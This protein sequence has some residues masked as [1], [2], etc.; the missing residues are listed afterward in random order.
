MIKGGESRRGVALIVVLG[1]LSIMIVMAV[2]FITQARM[3]RLVS[4]S[5]LEGMR[6][7]QL[8]RTALHAAMN[9][10][11]VELSAAQLVM[12]PSNSAYD[13]FVSVPPNAMAGM[14]GR[15]IGEDGVNPM[16]GEVED[17]IPRKF[18]N[19][20]YSANTTVSNEAQWILVRENPASPQPSRILG[21][22]AYAI[23][24]MSGGIDAN[25]I[26]KDDSVGGGDARMPSNRIR[27]SSRQVP[28]GLLPETANASQFKSYRNGWKGFDSLYALIK[29]TDGYP[30]DG[31]AGS[32]S[33]WEPER[34]EGAAPAALH[35]NLVSDLVPF[36]LSAF[37]GGR[38]N[39]A[40]NTW[41][42]FVQCNDSTPWSTVL[43]PIAGQ[44]AAGWQGWIANALYDYTH[45]TKVPQGT[46]Y[47]SPKNVP[48]FNEIVATYSLDEQPSGT[49]STYR[50]LLN[51]EFEFWY[52]FPSETNK[53]TSVFRLAAP[54]VTG[55][56]AAT[57]AGQIHM[58]VMMTTPT[59][60][61]AVQFGSAAAVP[62][63]LTV[64]ANY[65]TNRPYTPTAPGTNFVYTIPI[66]SM[67]GD[68]LPSGGALVVRGVRIA[69]PIYLQL[70]SSPGG[71]ADMIPGEL[72]F[73]G[74]GTTLRDSGVGARTVAMAATDPRLNHLAGQWVAEVPS[75][76]RMNAWDAATRT[77][78]E[79]EGTNMFC[80]NGPMETPAELGL[81]SNGRLWETIDLC[82][83]DA[84]NVLANLVTDTNLYAKWAASSAVAAQRVF[85]TN[86]TINP[87]T[88][89]SNV[90]ATAFFDLA[91]HEVPNT[92][93][94]FAATAAID[95]LTA[96]FLANQ[97]LLATST[98]T[99]TQAFQAGSD[100]ARIPAMQ[101][102]GAL[103]T[104]YGLNNNQRETLIRNTWGLFS[105]ENSLFT[106]VVVAQPI[107]E[108]PKKLGEWGDDDVVTGERRAVALVWRDPFRN[109]ANL[110]HEMFVRMFRYL[111][112]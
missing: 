37:R 43:N 50:L 39:A 8:L 109:G 52:P 65:N 71:N 20:P 3:E 82:T 89:S 84:A 55:N 70:Q 64:G 72:A 21:R 86:G 22:Y 93:N 29:L 35:S 77:K 106:V 45:D 44:F 12:A 41:T 2:A 30:N 81:I 88:R 62:G 34:K 110:H 59:G 74:A 102:G 13:L 47:P 107:K 9:D 19:V 91:A 14:D 99:V 112:D 33:R 104:A 18:T 56:P 42:P 85:Y 4:D 17:W 26:A 58:Q 48:M 7:R 98:G 63:A 5:T 61:V 57:G 60:P 15:K 1:F 78:F 103:A 80:R 100:W 23:F 25:L 11:S 40:G 108:G 6:G 73:V 10:Y 16:L 96:Q 31:N 24:D 66:E 111:N 32:D 87:N 94:K 68:P 53:T 97:I 92:T 83:P 69:Q 90:L 75:L 54:T 101:Q 76:G 51:M 36:S 38:Y 79:A 49:S 28:M 67:A 95:T 27:R 105:P 46:D